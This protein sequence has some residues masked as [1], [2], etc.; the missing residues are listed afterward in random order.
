MDE[1]RSIEFDPTGLKSIEEIEE[2]TQNRI[3]ENE[4]QQ[5]ACLV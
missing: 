2:S 5:Q 4:K 1:N 3:D